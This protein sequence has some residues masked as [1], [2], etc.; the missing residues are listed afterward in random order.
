MKILKLGKKAHCRRING[1]ATPTH[2]IIDRD[3]GRRYVVQP[4]GLKAD[5]TPY[6]RMNSVAESEFTDANKMDVPDIDPAY[7]DME[8]EDTMTGYKGVITHFIFHLGGCVH[9]AVQSQKP[10]KTGPTW[11][12][13]E[14]DVRKLKGKG[15]KK[16]LDA[17]TKADRPSPD[18]NFVL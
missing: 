5:K 12:I 8:V 15:I 7:F 3:G 18:M 6:D 17:V 11:N 13:E 1:K 14:V 4:E 9:A 2:M 10:S 16:L